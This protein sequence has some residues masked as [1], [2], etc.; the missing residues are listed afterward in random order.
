MSGDFGIS[1]STMD[2]NMEITAK[3]KLSFKADNIKINAKTTIDMKA[4]TDLQMEGTSAAKLTASDEHN[5]DAPKL[6][7]E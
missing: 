4:G 5:L 2:V 7:I 6:D 1:I 3:E